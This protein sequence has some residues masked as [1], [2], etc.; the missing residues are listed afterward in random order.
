MAKETP[1]CL[2]DCTYN[3]PLNWKFDAEVLKRVIISLEKSWLELK[4]KA[5][6]VK[7][8]LN[9][10]Q[11]WEEEIDSVNDH[12]GMNEFMTDAPTT[13]VSESLF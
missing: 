3:V 11:S 12:K 10:V 9:T 13:V 1:L 4:I 7:S 2:F 6:Q 5:D 8:M